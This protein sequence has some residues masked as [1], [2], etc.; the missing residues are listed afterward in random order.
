V[1]T[2]YYP[3]PSRTE[4]GVFIQYQVSALRQAGHQVDVVHLT[5]EVVWPLSKIK[6]FACL[7]N[8]GPLQQPGGRF[9]RRSIP[10][11]PGR[12]AG[13]DWA[14][15]LGHL[16]ARTWFLSLV[17]ELQPEIIHAHTAD[18]P[19]FL[20]LLAH[21]QLGLPLVVTTH[22]YDTEM[23][24]RFRYYLE[25]IRGIFEGA[26]RVVAVSPM[27][28]ALIQSLGIKDDNVRV[29]DNGV[30]ASLLKTKKDHWTPQAGRPLRLVTVNHL[31]P[32]KAADDTLRAIHLL[33]QRGLAL[34]FRIF[35]IGPQRAELEA[36]VQQLGLSDCVT[37]LGD[38]PGHRGALEEI[39]A[40]DL[41]CMPS[42]YEGFGVTYLEALAQSVPVIACEGQGIASL[43]AQS[44]GGLLVPPH[45]P[46]AVAEA[47]ASFAA[48]PRLLVEM[49]Q[50]GYQY[51]ALNNTWDAVA[52]KLVALYQE[53]LQEQAAG[54]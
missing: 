14:R 19:G 37:F 1:L 30:D 15:R 43:V 27:L 51:V 36:L 12:R 6:R 23:A 39:A 29:I 33:R 50:R 8:V 48:E 35:G 9:Y 46:A 31:I 13:G 44:Q 18:S 21:D 3:Y 28:A 25:R 20:G 22:G 40:A 11:L 17:R 10:L 52:R 26:D 42:W 41:Y 53:V 16:A 32:R 2:P 7:P 5:R 24:K 34:E 54:R 4:D 45:N 47:I 49:G 38:Q